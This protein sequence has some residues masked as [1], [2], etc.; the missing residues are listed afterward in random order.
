MWLLVV[1]NMKLVLYQLFSNPSGVVHPTTTIGD[2]HGTRH[3][4]LPWFPSAIAMGWYAGTRAKYLGFSHEP[5]QSG[6]WEERKKRGLESEVLNFLGFRT[7]DSLQNQCWYLLIDMLYTILYR[8]SLECKQVGVAVCMRTW[9]HCLLMERKADWVMSFYKGY[10]TYDGIE[11]WPEMEVDFA[12][13]QLIKT[14]QNQCLSLS[15]IEG[16]YCSC[17]R[18][19][20]QACQ[21]LDSGG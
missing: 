19:F 3:D 18:L 1:D 2:G 14:I 4:L 20:S 10:K 15:T 7:C 9:S 11:N 17:S 12:R 8:S 13:M 6:L 5:Q 16:K 21:P